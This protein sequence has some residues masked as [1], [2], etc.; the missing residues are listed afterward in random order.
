MTMSER[1]ATTSTSEPSSRCSRRPPAARRRPRLRAIAAACAA[2]L[3]LA[4]AAAAAETDASPAAAETGASHA[5]EST[6]G[7]DVEK[8][9]THFLQGVE[10]YNHGDFKL[11]LIE[12]RRSYDLSN[13]Y[14]ILY[15]IGQVNQQLGNYSKALA[16]LEQYLRDG[17]AEIA[18]D[19]R[20]EVAET[21]SGLRNRVAH[22]RI[23]TNVRAPEIL[24]D[25][26]PAE[27]EADGSITVDPGDH[28]VEVR[29]PGYQT[30][31]S[32]VSLAG[33]DKTEL[34]LTLQVVPPP[35]VLPVPS[36][37]TAPARDSTWLWIGWTATGAAALGAGITGVLASMQASELADLRNSPASTQSQRDN[38]GR[39]ARTFAVTSDVL[40][41]TAVAA[42]AVSLYLTL[43]PG[44]REQEPSHRGPVTSVALG[45]TGVTL[46]QSF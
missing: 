20:A 22:V 8:A 3:F 6:S 15:N 39:R 30:T 32:I 19:R 2:T 4:N 14:R 21:I 38:V 9:R 33:G 35:A 40:T 36:R 41:A 10:F 46:A 45:P 31:G 37:T 29:R 44:T 43:R 42:G 27:L 34:R 26:Y 24:L 12:F 25:G 28:R 5:M 11:S 7:T 1:I 18:D 23:L 17:A 16:A 13:N